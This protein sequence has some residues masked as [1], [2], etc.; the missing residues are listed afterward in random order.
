MALRCT[1][2]DVEW[3]DASSNNCDCFLNLE[4]ATGPD[5][6]YIDETETEQEKLHNKLDKIIELL[7][8]LPKKQTRMKFPG[9]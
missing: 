2:C 9:E 5:L 6:I 3:E 8:Q 7:E 4:V 1:K